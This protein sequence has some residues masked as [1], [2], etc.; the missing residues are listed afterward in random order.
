MADEMNT[1]DVAEVASIDAAVPVAKKPRA[2]RRAKAIAET[3]ATEEAPKVEAPVKERKKR[4]AKAGNSAASVSKP[5]QV[6]A[7]R[8]RAPG[9]PTKAAAAI[10]P[11][12][13]MDEM[14][15]LLQLEEENK[16]LRQSLAEKLRSEN[17]DLRKRLGIA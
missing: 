13:A 3:T 11:A 5:A 9:K 8:G 14:A 1:A 15:E 7:K 12:S 6:K 10:A 2:P 17:T 4:G 16:R